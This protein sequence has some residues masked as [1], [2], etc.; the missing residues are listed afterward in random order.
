MYADSRMTSQK[1]ILQFGKVEVTQKY[2]VFALVIDVAA[3]VVAIGVV[4]SFCC[5]YWCCC[6]V[7]DVVVVG[8]HLISS[9]FYKYYFINYWSELSIF[10]F[11]LQ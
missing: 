10:F 9:I 1:N 2:D 6:N 3:V 5:S 8:F 4:C 11:T 7:V